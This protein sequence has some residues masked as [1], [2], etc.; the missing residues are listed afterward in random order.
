MDAAGLAAKAKILADKFARLEH[1]LEQGPYFAGAMF[2][3]VDAAFGPVFR[4]FDVFDRIRDFGV[5]ADKPKVRAWRD[6]LARR[7][8]IQRAVAPHYPEALWTFLERRPSH[9]SCLMVNS[10]LGGRAAK[11]PSPIAAPL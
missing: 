7:P 4:Y 3:L 1:R 5:F 6:A 8:S 2:S 10:A 9:L 11:D